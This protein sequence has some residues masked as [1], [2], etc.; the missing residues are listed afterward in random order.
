MAGGLTWVD[1]GIADFL[2]TLH[3][4]NPDYFREYPD[5]LAYQRRVWAL[6]ELEEYFT[7]QFK[8]RPCNNYTA[9]WK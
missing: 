4:F 8:E 2:Q 6:P 3:I 1:F 9:V 7:T 5:L